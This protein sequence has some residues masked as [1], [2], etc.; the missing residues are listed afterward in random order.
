MVSSYT[1]IQRKGSSNTVLAH[2]ALGPQI[3]TE[4]N[5]PVLEDQTA[6][7]YGDCS[8]EPPF[9]TNT[10][11]DTGQSID[12]KLHPV[13]LVYERGPQLGADSSTQ[14]LGNENSRR[15]RGLQ[16]NSGGSR[17]RVNVEEFTKAGLT[18][19]HLYLSEIGPL[20]IRAAWQRS[21]TPKQRK[22]PAPSVM[23][24]IN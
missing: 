3:G 18:S 4:T 17:P 8:P 7:N 16:S 6:R 13:I 20:R 23:W 10:H 24:L 15:R 12:A 19:R 22:H 5:I 11:T 21:R 2:L 1:G 14:C 9:Q